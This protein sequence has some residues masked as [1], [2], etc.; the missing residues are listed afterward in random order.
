MKA[1]VIGGSGFLGSHVAD[2]LVAAGHQVRILDLRPSAYATPDQEVVIGDLLNVTSVQQAVE[3]CDVV[4][5]MAGIADLD[6]ATTQ[7]RT[8]IELNVEGNVVA[9]DVAA[10]AG[11][12]RFVYASTIYVYSAKGGFY[13][14]SKQASELYVEEYQRQYGLDYT[15]LRYGT[16]Y[17]PRSDERNSI[18]RYL[19][20]ALRDGR[21]SVKGT[22]DESREY[23]EV[24][25]A[26]RLTVDILGPEYQ[27][28]HVIITGHH[29]IKLSQLLCTIQEILNG[30]VEVE[31]G[32]SNPDHYDLV[33]YSYTPKL[34]RKLTS[35]YFMDIGQGLLELI[36][37]MDSSM[38]SEAGR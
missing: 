32:G 21:I 15:I 14:C 9:L 35:N 13:R 22:G 29:Q 11:C 7:P 36:Q 12:A 10:R 25:D 6:D 23:I 26:A 34:G 16:L 30:A 27:N 5:N 19:N 33:P 20:Q 2:A 38:S 1:L 18:W 8:T 37:A 3:G 17:G 28:S 24:R 31:Y 4:Y